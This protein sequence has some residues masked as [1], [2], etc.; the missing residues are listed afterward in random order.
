MKNKILKSGSLLLAV[1]I[2]HTMPVLAQDAKWGTLNGSVEANM[3]FFQKD[4]KLGNLKPEDKFAI[5]TWLN[6]NYA[7]RDF[8][9]R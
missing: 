5:N 6:L 8:P 3:G 9:F 7:F 1:F 2:S 4:K